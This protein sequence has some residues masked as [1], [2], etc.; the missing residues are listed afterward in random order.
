MARP[1][2]RRYLY[3]YFLPLLF[4]LLISLY[5]TSSLFHV[6][7]SFGYIILGAVIYVKNCYLL[8]LNLHIH[9]RYFEPYTYMKRLHLSVDF[10]IF[11]FAII[12]DFSGSLSAY[13]YSLIVARVENTYIFRFAF[14]TRM[15][16]LI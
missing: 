10:F 3:Y 14:R 7:L 9:C 12:F 4:L 11:A 2:L 15:R 16:T 6:C 13:K 5:N 1:N 8:S